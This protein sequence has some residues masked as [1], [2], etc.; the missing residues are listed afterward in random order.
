MWERGEN[1]KREQVNL[2]VSHQKENGIRMPFCEGVS[3][4]NTGK[5]TTKNGCGMSGKKSQ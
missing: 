2:R 1:R 3:L 5:G 4:S